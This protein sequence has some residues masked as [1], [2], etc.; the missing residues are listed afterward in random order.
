MKE[1]DLNQLLDSIKETIGE[2]VHATIVNDIGTLITKNS[3]VIKEL[4]SRDEEITRL[5]DTNEKLIK[6]NGAL[7]QQIPAGKVE[8]PKA[9]SKVEYYDYHS[10][11]DENGNF[12]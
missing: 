10:A 6:A 4:N 8:P 12:K 1:E 9:E 7:L 5:K 3:E 2:D 11:F